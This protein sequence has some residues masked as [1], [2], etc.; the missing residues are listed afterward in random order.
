MCFLESTHTRANV[1]RT[2]VFTY[3][4]LMRSRGTHMCVHLEHNENAC[5]IQTH[6]CV[7]VEHTCVH[8]EHKDAQ[9][10]H[11]CVYAWDTHMCTTGTQTCVHLE[12]RVCD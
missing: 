10:K 12:H 9:L 11:T 1:E 5:P 3:D 2:Y 4:T 7:H 6:M 8:L